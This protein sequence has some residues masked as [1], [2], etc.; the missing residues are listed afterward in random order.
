MIERAPV[1]GEFDCVP[2]QRKPYGTVDWAEHQEAWA[3][4]NRRYPG[5]DQSAQCIA[6][7]GG[8][9]YREITEFLGHEPRTWRV[10]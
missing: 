5:N 7:R 2:S 10:R 8:F 6:Q 9:G 1:Q 3:V 4:Y